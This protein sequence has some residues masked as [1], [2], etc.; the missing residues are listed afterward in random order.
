MKKRE[1]VTCG[2]ESGGGGGAGDG[3][4]L[5][6]VMDFPLLQ[7]SQVRI[8]YRCSLSEEETGAQKH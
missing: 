6:L 3:P 8:Y 1:T 5:C 7:P 4:G 2:A